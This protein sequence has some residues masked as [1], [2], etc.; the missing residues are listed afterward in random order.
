MAMS[1][2][3][4]MQLDHVIGPGGA[5]EIVAL[6]NSGTAVQPSTRNALEHVVDGI[7][8]ASA[9]ITRATSHTGPALSVATMNRLEHEL[10]GRG[11][12]EELN[13]LVTGGGA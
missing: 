9:F 4:K 7:G 1:T 10:G 2:A 8:E 6:I 13:T 3:L 11:N 12:A 5:A